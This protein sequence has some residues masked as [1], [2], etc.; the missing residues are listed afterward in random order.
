MDRNGE[1]FKLLNQLGEV[2]KKNFLGSI[3][4]DEETKKK[5]SE[6]WW[7]GI[8]FF[9]QR[10]F[11]QGRNDE[12]SKKYYDATIGFL[13]KEKNNLKKLDFKELWSIINPKSKKIDWGKGKLSRAK[14]KKILDSNVIIKE[15]NLKNEQEF[16]SNLSDLDVNLKAEDILMIISTLAYVQESNGNFI[17][18]YTY[19]KSQLIESSNE[20]INPNN[21]VNT[22]K[23]LVCPSKNGSCQN[24]IK[25]RQIGPK[26]ASLVIRDILLIENKKITCKDINDI[27]FY[28]SLTPL[29]CCIFPIDTWVK[30]VY[31]DIFDN[32]SSN[33]SLERKS[34]S[35]PCGAS[36]FTMEQREI[37][38]NLTNIFEMSLYN[39]DINILEVAAGT[40]V[41]GAFSFE[42]VLTLLK[43]TDN[44]VNE[45]LQDIGIPQEKIW[46]FYDCKES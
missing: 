40:W 35:I 44:K 39:T 8:Q 25:I 41:L 45:F 24:N 17:N 26:I 43:K 11:P 42:I 28:D 5:L 46:K 1:I 34:L 36:I 12:L 14:L 20:V 13:K 31:M 23:C 7:Y 29:L 2:Y 21:I 38:E 18:I 16:V 4:K 3:V 37:L 32:G 6:D 30:K 15:K 27:L 22:F 33:K 10:T 9:F 19:L